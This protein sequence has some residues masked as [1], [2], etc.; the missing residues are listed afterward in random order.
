MNTSVEPLTDSPPVDPVALP[1]EWAEWAEEPGHKV[2]IEEGG[3]VLG[4][5]H[6][7]V[8]GPAEGW[9]E[10]LWVPPAARGKGIG[11]QLVRE[12]EGLL[13]GYGVGTMRTAIPAR[14]YAALAVAERAG[15]SRST[16]ASVLVAGIARGP[17]DITYDARAR[18]ATRAD[19]AAIFRLLA[20]SPVVS[21]WRGLIP[22]GW[23]FRQ[24]RPEL[25][26]GLIN[27]GRVVRVGE[28]V[29]G[30]AA[31]AVHSTTAVV[32]L[33][34]GPRAHQAALFG[35]VAE[36]ARTAG[37]DRIV[38]FAPDPTP[39]PGIRASFV[40]HDWCPDGLVIV[41]KTLG[42]TEGSPERITGM[43]P[44]VGHKPRRSRR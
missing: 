10:G 21:A 34:E 27:D 12:A 16:E 38:M 32:F 18:P 40:P 7:A 4:V 11:G 43:T 8:V 36:H 15:F 42:I 17:I 31:F 5:L 9:L 22:L 25:L 1:R 13:R 29:E 6:V 14:E 2:T 35:A 3:R 30:V 33:L 23:R 24:I 37:A 26:R 44:P 19:E 41:E 39:P 20:A 28:T